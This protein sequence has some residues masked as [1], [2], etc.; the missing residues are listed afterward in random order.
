MNRYGKGMVASIV[1]AG[2]SVSLMLG[3]GSALAGPIESTGSASVEIPKTPG[4]LDMTMTINGEER[5]YKS[6][7]DWFSGTLT[8][9]WTG[10]Q[11]EP[12]TTVSGCPGG[13]PGGRILLEETT[14]SATVWASWVSPSS[15]VVIGPVQLPTREG[16]VAAAVCS[17]GPDDGSEPPT[18]PCQKSEESEPPAE[19]GNGNGN[20]QGQGHGNGNGNGQGNGH[21]GEKPGQGHGH[22]C[23]KVS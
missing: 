10:M 9:T 1:A 2:A 20:G 4:N 6:V 22:S 18:V 8:L 13:A 12:R 3:A 5:E 19:T 14:P 21:G 7:D 23:G 15:Q 11:R 16:F 17:D